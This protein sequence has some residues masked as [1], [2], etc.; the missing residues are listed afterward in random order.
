MTLIWFPFQGVP[1]PNRKLY[2]GLIFDSVH[3]KNDIQNFVSSMT[4]GNSIYWDFYVKFIERNVGTFHCSGQLISLVKWSLLLSNSCVDPNGAFG[5]G[6]R[7]A[8]GARPPMA[9]NF[10]NFMQFFAKFGK[11]ICSCPPGGLSPPPMGNPGSAPG[12]CTAKIEFEFTT[13]AWVQATAGTVMGS[14][15][16]CWLPFQWWPTQFF[17]FVDICK[18][19]DGDEFWVYCFYGPGNRARK[20]PSIA[21]LAVAWT[22]AQVVNL[23]STSSGKETHS[24]LYFHFKV[25]DYRS[26]RST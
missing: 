21:V 5:G 23:N 20:P 22:Q 7:G 13:R 11:I 16:H 6:G 12:F 26:I 8:P 2:L 1:C 14:G 17:L 4:E 19:V 15:H 10:L 18:W 3:N 24:C 9:Q 25:Q